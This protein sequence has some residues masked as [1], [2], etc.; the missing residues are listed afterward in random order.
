M[1]R[2]TSTNRRGAYLLKTVSTVLLCVVT[3][4]CTSEDGLTTSAI[5]KF[6]KER[7]AS[8]FSEELKEKGSATVKAGDGS[9]TMTIS[10][11]STSMTPP[12]P[13]GV[14]TFFRTEGANDV[15]VQ[16]TARENVEEVEKF[17][18]SSFAGEGLVEKEMT[19]LNGLFK[20]EW[21]G[22]DGKPRAYVYAYRDEGGPSHLAVALVK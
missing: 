8:A 21:V 14:E 11:K 20:G 5:Q 13:P 9:V 10:G 22:Q 2:Q 17:Y 1:P 15:T 12:K 16:M 7:V 3:A 4:S 18:R 19:S 6:V